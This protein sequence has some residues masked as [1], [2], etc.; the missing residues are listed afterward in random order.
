[1]SKPYIINEELDMSKDKAVDK[2]REHKLEGYNF[3]SGQHRLINSIENIDINKRA[4]EHYK[5]ACDLYEQA[6][7]ETRHKF[8]RDVVGIIKDLEDEFCGD[9]GSKCEDRDNPC[10]KIEQVLLMKEKIKSLEES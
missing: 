10:Y 7:A 3:T 4:V 5:I 6:L 1:M 2:A 8:I 9:C